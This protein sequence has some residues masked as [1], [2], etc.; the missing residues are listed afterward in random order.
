[1]DPVKHKQSSSWDKYRNVKH[2]YRVSWRQRV[3]LAFQWRDETRWQSCWA[4]PRGQTDE[5]LGH[6]GA[7]EI[8]SIEKYGRKRA[9]YRI[10]NPSR[11]QTGPTTSGPSRVPPLDRH[12]VHPA[13]T[14]GP[15]QEPL[16]SSS[17]LK[18]FS[19]DF[20][21]LSI[22]EMKSVE[23]KSLNLLLEAFPN[24][25]AI[26]EDDPA[27]VTAQLEASKAAAMDRIARLTIASSEESSNVVQLDPCCAA[28]KAKRG[29]SRATDDERR[30][31]RPRP[32]R[33]RPGQR[34]HARPV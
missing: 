2:D 29:Q 6:L 25:E 9:V 23:D 10:H 19:S 24:A 22:P 8:V 16:P 7:A 3:L 26:A 18:K 5:H 30:D 31:A 20:V 4:G 33:C 34:R 27:P 32:V 14:S 15:S 17:G 13:A 12:T 21:R 11:Q 28:D 1:M